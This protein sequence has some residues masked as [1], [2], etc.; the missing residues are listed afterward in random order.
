MFRSGAM[1][2]RAS[3][4]RHRQLIP[5]ECVPLAEAFLAPHRGRRESVRPQAQGRAAVGGGGPRVG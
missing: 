2:R 4:C 3:A 1:L 5:R